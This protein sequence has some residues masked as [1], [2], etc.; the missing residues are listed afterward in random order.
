MTGTATIT[1]DA[2]RATL[3]LA[4]KLGVAIVCCW[5]LLGIS[6]PWIT[7]L[8][9]NAIDLNNVLKAPGEHGLLGTDQVGRDMLTRVLFAA[10][11][12]M[13][14]GFLGVIIP[15]L[16][17]VSV[18]VLSGYFGGRTDLVMMRVV[19]VTIAFPFLILVL[20]I[21]GILGPGFIN[22][23]IA[24]TAVG[25]V[26]YA[27]LIRAEVL[28]VKNTE[29]VLA[30]RTLGYT[31]RY[32]ILHHVLPNSISPVAVYMMT[33]TVLV[34]LAGASLGFVG[35]GLQPPTAEWGVMIADGQAYIEDAWWICVF[36]GLALITLGVGLSLIGDGLARLLRVHQ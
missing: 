9:P 21:V 35:F 13:A 16:I 25:W 18:G 11:I 28:V 12:D 27:R 5:L 19:D 1:H 30:A 36:P 22:I 10:R 31:P 7:G 23:I 24:L 8:D 34:M 14:L 20:A 3:P 26:A 4:L 32:I 33:D 15:M 2:E 17:G 29:Y 6:A